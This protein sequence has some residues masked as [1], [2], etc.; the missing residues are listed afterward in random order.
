MES[1]SCSMIVGALECQDQAGHDEF[2]AECSLAQTY[3]QTEDFRCLDM[4]VTV[5]QPMLVM[6]FMIS[7]DSRTSEV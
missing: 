2:E 6:L 5:L 3:A 1:D 7:L 4:L